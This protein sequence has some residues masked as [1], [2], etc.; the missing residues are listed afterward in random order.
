MRTAPRALTAWTLLALLLALAGCDDGGSGADAGG[1]DAG[2]TVVDAGPPAP[3]AGLPA[4]DAG[5]PD[6]GP[7]APRC[8]LDGPASVGYRE[9]AELTWASQGADEA[10]LFAAGVDGEAVSLEGARA[11][12]PL[13]LDLVAELEVRSASGATSRCRIEV[14]VA[15]APAP[16]ILGVGQSNM[17]RYFSSAT[18]NA[19]ELERAVEALPSVSGDVTFVSAARGGSALLEANVASAPD[20][21]WVREATDGF[22]PGPLLDAA[23]TQIATRRAGGTVDLFLWAQG[24]RDSGAISQRVFGAGAGIADAA[25]RERR[26]LEEVDRYER[27]LRYL[28]ATLREAAGAPDVPFAIQALGR[29]TY[30]RVEAI[31]DQIVMRPAHELRRLQHRLAA[32]MP[33]VRVLAETYDA[34][35]TDGI[36]M[37]AAGRLQTIQR[38]AAALEVWR[39]GGLA[40]GPVAREARRATPREVALR[41]DGLSVVGALA[42]RLFWIADATGQPLAPALEATASADGVTLRFADELPADARLLVAFGDLGTSPSGMHIGYSPA[43]EGVHMFGAASRPVATATLPVTP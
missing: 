26:L 3:D 41:V 15:P 37:D 13:S 31:E 42:H 27:A 1:R 5:A 25:E 32:E 23:L 43:Q 34:P 9:R 28:V 2:A 24:E 21:Y 36:H 33:G 30:P 35:Y 6:A 40:S 12:G 29:R 19:A 16:W 20:N 18:A 10:T 4:Q 11:I 8:V 14:R 22:A 17:A 39:T 7:A 38:L